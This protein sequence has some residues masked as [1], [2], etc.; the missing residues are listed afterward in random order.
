VDRPLITFM[1]IAYN[2]EQYIGEAIRGAF[3]QTYSPLEILLSDDCSADR[4]FEIMREMADGYSG[5]YRV[6]LNRNMKNLGLGGHIDHL[7]GLAQGEL[8]VVAA[9]DDVSVPARA[10]KTWQAYVDSGGSAMSIY[11]SM[12]VIDEHGEKQEIVS[13]P[14]HETATDIEAYLKGG[15]VCG[16]SHAWHR[17]VFEVFGP[18]VPGTVYEDKVIPFRSVML[19]EIRYI[20]EPLVLYRRHSQSIT[21]PQ[22]CSS[23]EPDV[24]AHVVKRQT[25]RLL[26]LRNYERDLL[27]PHESIRIGEDIRKRL[28]ASVHTQIRLLELEI[29]FDEG[30]FRDRV[31]VIGQ[32]VS[33]H[34]GVP[35]LAKWCV[36]LVYPY[37][38][39][40]TRRKLRAELANR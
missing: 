36:Q 19:G 20:D 33:A 39:R 4:T 23:T 5:P 35:R 6:R 1:L 24:V 9:G 30:T 27:L 21:G 32:G 14:P 15:G 10:E 40:R 16:C 37:R 29:A 31:R 17:R 8:I 26:T 18:M 12:M 28:A 2:Q 38:L 13:K 22:S 34:V 25:R 11:S 3:S 7:M